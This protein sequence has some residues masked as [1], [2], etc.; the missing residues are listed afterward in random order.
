MSYNRQLICPVYV[1]DKVRLGRDY[2]GGYIVHPESVRGTK[3]LLSFGIR[4]DWSFEED[5]HKLNPD[6]Q[7]DLYDPFTPGSQLRRKI[8]DLLGLRVFKTITAAV[9]AFLRINPK[10]KLARISK[11]IAPP[12]PPS[13]ALFEQ[14]KL[15]LSK[16]GAI[17]HAVGVAG[18]S[19]SLLFSSCVS[20]ID[21]LQALV[22]KVFPALRPY[23][24]TH[25][26]EIFENI[27]S[28]EPVFL[29][30]DIEGAEYQPL[31]ELLPYSKQL[32]GLV[33]EF[34]NLDRVNLQQKLAF[35]IEE[36]RKR[37]LFVM[38]VHANSSETTVLSDD[39]YPM[40]VIPEISFVHRRFL[41]PGP[42]HLDL[43]KYPIEGLD[44]PNGPEW[45]DQ[46][47]LDFRDLE[48]ISIP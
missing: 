11:G 44:Q 2:D 39:N 17:Y 41:E 37:D 12:M 6:I 23:R 35:L 40:P 3:H 16:S 48:Q 33:L 9:K 19:E 1:K 36:F 28:N 34:H 18:K 14:L 10:G 20:V 15:F 5:F 43:V 8:Y 4:D 46:Y 30:M 21:R 29:K 47:E 45:P 31:E 38:H 25:I 42:L 22:A 27:D 13:T 32:T 24:F 26:A 7:T